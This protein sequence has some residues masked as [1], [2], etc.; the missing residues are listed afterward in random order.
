MT[1]RR[2]MFLLVIVIWRVCALACPV[3]LLATK[4]ALAVGFR[5]GELLPA[6]VN[7]ELAY[8]TTQTKASR[9]S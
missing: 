1:L 4:F 7:G 2:A 6:L 9:K 8:Y 3:S 5:R